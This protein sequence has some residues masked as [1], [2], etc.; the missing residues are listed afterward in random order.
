MRQEEDLFNLCGVINFKIK[1]HHKKL[2][3]NAFEKIYEKAVSDYNRMLIRSIA[4]LTQKDLMIDELSNLSIEVNRRNNIRSQ[5]VF[6]ISKNI[7]SLMKHSLNMLKKNLILQKQNSQ[8]N[9]SNVYDN[10]KR[11]TGEKFLILLIF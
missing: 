6:H 8:N 5:S 3:E 2:T 1:K 10:S 9:F 4:V 7:S 11:F